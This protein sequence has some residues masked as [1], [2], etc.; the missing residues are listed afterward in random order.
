MRFSRKVNHAQR[1]I[2]HNMIS[3]LTMVVMF[4][5]HI[6]HMVVV[7]LYTEVHMELLSWVWEE[8]AVVCFL[9][10]HSVIWDNQHFQPTM[11]HPCALCKIICYGR[12]FNKEISLLNYV[13]KSRNFN[14]NGVYC[15]T[16]LGNKWIHTAFLARKSAGVRYFSN[17]S[18]TVLQ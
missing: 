7:I 18:S 9:W 5:L 13:A 15:R 3:Q 12:P 11:V 10:G 6:R 16:S 4:R 2:D 17:I 14:L 8:L 1:V